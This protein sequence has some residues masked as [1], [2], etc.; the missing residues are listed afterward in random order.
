MKVLAIAQ[1]TF[2]EARRDRAQWILLLYAVIVLGGAS[3]L[4]PLA[5]G[6]GYRVTRDLGLAGI[7]LIG[8]VLIVL[9]GGGLVQKE[10]ERQTVLTVLSRPLRRPEFLL[11]KY[12]GLLGMVTLVFLGMT[13]L[14]AGILLIKEGHLEAAVLWAALFTLG[15]LALMTA[16]VVTFSAFVSPALAG[17]FTVAMF[18]VGHF[19][20]DLPRFA[21]KTGGGLAEIARGLY[22]FLPHLEAFNLRAE[23]AYGIVPE[24]G[25]VAGAA[26]YV[27]LYTAALLAGGAVIFSRREFR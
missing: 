15:E 6:E 17:V 25:R 27:L 1:N 11:G 8:L 2:R 3:V 20:E 19:A 12:L 10:V 7:S 18:L 23:A 22:V 26:L 24:P 14:L 9:V 16:V 5:M 13:A 4:S 21:E